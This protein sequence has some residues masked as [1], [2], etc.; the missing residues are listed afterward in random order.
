MLASGN[1]RP[2][3]A[4]DEG[5]LQREPGPSTSLTDLPMTSSRD[6]QQT[7]SVIDEG[8]LPSMSVY[9]RRRDVVGKQRS[10]SSR[11]AS[12]LAR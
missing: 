5:L 7:R 10:C 11:V 12:A 4:V 9:T 1:A 2:G 6:F 3:G 8:V